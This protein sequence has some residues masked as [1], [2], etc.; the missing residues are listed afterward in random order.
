MK[1]T[2]SYAGIESIRSVELINSH[3][4]DTHGLPNMFALT[5][6]LIHT[7]QVINRAS[8]SDIHDEYYVSLLMV[9]YCL[10]LDYQIMKQYTLVAVLHLHV[11]ASCYHCY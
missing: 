3:N 7:Y 6:R 11:L 8:T 1:G 5:L 4:T 10:V 9:N 2:I